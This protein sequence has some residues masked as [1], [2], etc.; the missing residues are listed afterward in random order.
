M[1]ELRGTC[2]LKHSAIKGIISQAQRRFPFVT[3][4]RVNFFL[5]KYELEFADAQLKQTAITLT[6]MEAYVTPTLTPFLSQT[7]S[8]FSFEQDRFDAKNLLSA[9]MFLWTT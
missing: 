2:T 7:A 5:K 6:Q 8:L 4:N 1:L 9:P 3:R